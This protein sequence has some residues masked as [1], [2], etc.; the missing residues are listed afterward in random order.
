MQFSM[1][2]VLMENLMI[3]EKLYEFIKENTLTHT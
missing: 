3:D 2:D 1:E